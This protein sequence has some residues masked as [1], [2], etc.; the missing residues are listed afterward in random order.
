M[1]DGRDDEHARGLPVRH[2]GRPLPGTE[3]RLAEDGELLVRS[4]T[5]FQGYF[6]DPE[7]TAEVL[8]KTAGC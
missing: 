2:R 3:V 6:K 1:H 4:E 7:A 8:A 5:V